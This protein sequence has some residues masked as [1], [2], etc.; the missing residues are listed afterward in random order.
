M[1]SEQCP[2]C[3][4]GLRLETRGLLLDKVQ[5]C[6]HCGFERDVLDE[7]TIQ[8]EEAGKKVTIHR[9]DLGTQDVSDAML[10]DSEIQSRVREMTGMDIADLM[11]NAQSIQGSGK[12][13]SQTTTTTQTFTGPEAEQRL[14]EMGIDLG[15][16][17]RD[18]QAQAKA[19][20]PHRPHKMGVPIAIG[21]LLL[22]AGLL[23]MGIIA[24]WVL[25]A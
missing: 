12:N 23:V 15:Q 25:F 18:S 2:N 20:A 13:I 5:T 8:E 7:V 11:S 17:V 3:G 10:G 4:A 22:V 1:S 6:S 16:V 24:G 14:A 19:A 9:K 21:V